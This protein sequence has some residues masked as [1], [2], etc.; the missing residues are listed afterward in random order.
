MSAEAGPIPVSAPVRLLVVAPF[1]V[2]GGAER[3]LC[4]LLDAT[5][6]LEVVAVVLDSGPLVEQLRDR[7]IASQVRATGARPPDLLRAAASVRRAARRHRAE[8]VLANGVKAAA[9]CAIARAGGAAPYVW[10]KHDF[11]FDARLARPLARRAAAV[12]ANSPE[13]AA[14]TGRGDTRIIPPPAPQQPP[15]PAAAARDRL[16]RLG[17]PAQGRLLAVVGRLVPYKGVDTAIDALGQP[18]AAGWHLVVLGGH[19]PS[20]PGEHDRL[21]QRARARGVDQRVHLL[22]D[23]ADAGRLISGADA[24]GV[25]SRRDRRGFGREGYSMVALEAR[26]AGVPLIAGR[27]NP[28]AARLATAHGTVVDDRAPGQVAAALSALAARPAGSAP[29][30]EAHPDAAACAS[31][32][33]ACCATAAGRPGAGLGHRPPVSVVT[34]ARNEA[35]SIDGLLD[36]IG[37]QLGPDDECLVVDDASTDATRARVGDHRRRTGQIRLIDGPG[38]NA[39]AARN[40]GFAAARCEVVVSI[41]AGCVPCPGWLDALTTPFTDAEPS[42]A[43]LGVYQVAATTAFQR[44]LAH[45]CYPDPE[46]ARGRRAWARVYHRIAGVVFDARHFD[47]RTA[48]VTKDAWHRVGGFPTAMATDEDLVFG[49]R[50]HTGGGSVVLAAHSQVRWTPR[51]TLRDT[52][53]MYYRY[54]IGDAWSGHGPVIGRNVARATA[55]VAVPPAVV[56]HRR[57]LR[58]LAGAGAAAYWSLPVA[59]AATAG[60]DDRRAM[61]LIPLALAVKDLAK[62]TGCVVGLV[63]RPSRW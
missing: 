46:E 27:S 33:A 54:G 43:V 42:D 14:A 44:A 61:P 39:A 19:D 18:G 36:G 31:R 5:D 57:W 17:A 37:A 8:V 52:A 58:V 24:V 56:A 53:R 26:R 7:G 45:A 12:V 32:L 63:R 55:A 2:L 1:A 10:A 21:R 62:A 59:R 60:G 11:S 40:A 48:A 34:P 38:R 50:L 3:W 25:L 4:A 49:A 22:G 16:R 28:V 30:L 51:T 29:G 15:L 23:V 41:D 9:V 47:T 6:R 35:G 13:V 20:A